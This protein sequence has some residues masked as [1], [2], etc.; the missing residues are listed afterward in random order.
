MVQKKI[1]ITFARSL[2]TLDLARKLSAAGHQI[3]VADSVPFHLCRFSKAIQEPFTVPSPRF[4]PEEYIRAIVNITKEKKIDIVIPVYE[5]T[6]LIAKN[7][8]LFPDTCTLFSPTFE[9]FNLLHNKWLFQ[10]KLTELDIK[11]PS[12]F[13]IRENKEL[14]QLTAGHPFALKASYS[15]ASQSVQKFFPGEAS[16]KTNISSTNPLIAQ[17][18]IDGEKYCSYAICRDGIVQALATYPVTY[19]IDGNSCLIFEAIQHEGIVNWIKNFVNKMEYT[20][21]ISFDFIQ[22][23]KNRE[24]YAIECNPRATSGLHLFS[25]DDGLDKAILQ[26]IDSPIFPALGRR[27]Q[28]LWG[29]LLYGWKKNGF[30]QSNLKQYISTV[31]TTKD[32]VFSASDLKPFL[33]EP[34]IFAS[35]FFHSRKKKQKIPTY[36]T[37]DHDWNGAEELFC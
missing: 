3:Y 1:L 16:Y 28:I 9:N 11:T 26:K 36:F 8:E 6:W 24:L 23:A 7:K 19:A 20:G 18:W 30:T 22:S 4:C 5:E 17:E 34:L 13:L 2:W 29:M 33:F 14:E 37:F 12:Y 31:L 35:I 10:K 27:Q 15:R 32:V 21:Q 25:E